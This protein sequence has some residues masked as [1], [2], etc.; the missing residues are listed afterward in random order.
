MSKH[1]MLCKQWVLPSGN[2]AEIFSFAGKRTFHFK[3][4]LKRKEIK[5]KSRIFFF[6]MLC[7]CFILFQYSCLLVCFSS[8]SFYISLAGKFTVT[9]YN[10]GKKMTWIKNFPWIQQAN[11]ICINTTL[12][13]LHILTLPEP[14]TV[15]I[16][17]KKIVNFILYQSRRK[18]SNKLPSTTF[19]ELQKI[20]NQSIIFRTAFSCAF[21]KHS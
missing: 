6:V 4:F 10:M 1:T 11:T 14:K 8:V 7:F 2:I 13:V 19:P 16:R 17:K 9:K 3:A 15:W 12:H 5:I 18:Q 21:L 20:G